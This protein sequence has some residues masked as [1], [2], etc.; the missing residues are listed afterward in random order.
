[1]LRRAWYC[2]GKSFVRLSV[3]LRYPDHIGWNT[4]KIISLLVSLGCS[5]SADTNITYL[6][7]GELARNFGRNRGGYRKSG[8]GVQK[9]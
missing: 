5:L 6:L 3:T 4:A 9:L 7:Q 2:C 1:M 8:L